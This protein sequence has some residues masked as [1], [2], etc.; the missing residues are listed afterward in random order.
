MK[1]E[2]KDSL[3]LSGHLSKYPMALTAI[4][5]L[6]SLFFAQRYE[7]SA[8]YNY[9]GTS[10]EFTVI[11]MVF[12]VALGALLLAIVIGVVRSADLGKAKT[13]LYI[14]AGAGV[15]F[16]AWRGISLLS[17]TS[18]T[19]CMAA[20]AAAFT[21][22]CL[23]FYIKQRLLAT[24]LVPCAV[25]C[26]G[27]CIGFNLLFYVLATIV[28]A[29]FV[30]MDKKTSLAKRIVALGAI[31]FTAVMVPVV[32][33]T[34]TVPTEGVFSAGLVLVAG[35]TLVAHLRGK[36]NA[37]VPILF[38][39]GLG[40]VMRL[41]YV[42]DVA[43]PY[44]QHDV[45]SVFDKQ[46]PRHNSYIMYIYQNMAL[47][48]E[49]VYNAGLSQYY[50]PPL[51]HF[52]AA[53]WIKVQTLCGIDLY[54]AYE[55]VQ[56]FTL[57]CSAAMMTVAYKV[58]LEFK[59]KGVALYTAFAIVAFHPTFY[60]FAG[61]ANNDPLTTLFLFLAVLYTVRWYKETSF[62]NTVLLAFSIG[63]AMMTKLSG[64]MVAFGTAYVMLH[65]LFTE[66][67]GGFFENVQRLW[68]RFVA[69]AALCFPLGLWWSVRCAVKY[70]MPLGY[71]PALSNNADQY[72]GNHSFIERITGIG[73]FSFSNM[74]ANIGMTAM[75][76]SAAAAENTFYDYGIAPYIV[77]S[78]LFGEFFVKTKVSPM[79]NVLAYVMVI[80]SL[81]LIALSLYAMVK[82][83]I[84]KRGEAAV[85]Y[86]FLGVFY[87][88]LVGSYVA[89]CFNYPHT[90]TM[91]F[92]YIVPT[93]L[94]GAVFTGVYLNEEGR[95]KGVKYAAFAI[96]AVFAFASACFYI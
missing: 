22:L 94:I 78:A 77:K 19:V 41:N 31:A 27:F 80:S 74:F 73:S 59:L 28:Y 7:G 23:Y 83:L 82:L 67:T 51:F 58:F 49:D 2:L 39:F 91:D 12:G 33:N 65:K 81:V 45:F 63:L 55:N 1:N 56:Y 18:F 85:P 75:D 11:T 20:L 76:G 87:L 13:A 89:F 26:L 4:I 62:K 70:G 64:A 69:F 57:F 16:L 21:A 17:G 30:F 90:C 54:K 66:K 36:I 29:F 52:L 95:S 53:L 72:I 93:L 38:M 96:T 48:T 47:P 44:N 14:G 24:A 88:A 68:T 43:L 61:S 6:C 84:K 37:P 34:A 50:H 71:V 40:L 25:L 9:L 3:A 79:Q 86:R 60:I 15:L 8:Y 46:Y 92:R 42:L 35:V 32:Y 5:C 10:G